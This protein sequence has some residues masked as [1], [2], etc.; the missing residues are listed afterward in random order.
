LKE[1]FKKRKSHRGLQSIKII[2]KKSSRKTNRK[3][4]KEVPKKLTIKPLIVI[5]GELLIREQIILHQQ[6]VA[7]KL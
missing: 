6:R 2:Q 1:L 4:K 5:S 7:D 3:K